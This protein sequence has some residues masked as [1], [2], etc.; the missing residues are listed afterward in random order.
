MYNVTL[1]MI[2]DDW[3]VSHFPEDMVSHNSFI[4]W[5]DTAR[6]GVRG[7]QGIA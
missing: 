2:S 1:K 7:I 6:W 3:P 4:D 5:H